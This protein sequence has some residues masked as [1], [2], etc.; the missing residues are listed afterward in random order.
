MFNILKAVLQERK[1]QS[2]DEMK[3]AMQIWINEQQN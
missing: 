3:T 2:K 1:F